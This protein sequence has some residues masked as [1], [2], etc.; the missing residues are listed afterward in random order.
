MT[1]TNILRSKRDLEPTWQ[2]TAR[3]LNC[4]VAP[5]MPHRSQMLDRIAEHSKLGDRAQSDSQAHAHPGCF[6]RIETHLA[7]KTQ[8]EDPNK[9]P[10]QFST[11]PRE[12]QRNRQPKEKLK[13]RCAQRM[14][15]RHFPSPPDLHYVVTSHMMWSATTSSDVQTK[16]C[17]VLKVAFS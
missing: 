11:F 6:W 4:K 10:Q 5:G 12:Q 7:S 9:S 1:T 3:R 8:K 15:S 13:R 14:Q 16:C 2:K 17:L